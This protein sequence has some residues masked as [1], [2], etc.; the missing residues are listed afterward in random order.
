MLLWGQMSLLPM[1]GMMGREG[2]FGD[3][4]GKVRSMYV[5]ARWFSAWI[6]A[7]VRT[8]RASLSCLEV[9]RGVGGLSVS[10]WNG[11]YFDE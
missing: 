4:E 1:V 6:S 3:G 11:N 7:S 9:W 8:K 5:T 2:T 10:S